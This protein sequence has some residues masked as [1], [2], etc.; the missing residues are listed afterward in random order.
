MLR[1]KGDRLF[2]TRPN[3]K[4]GEGQFEL[5]HI[6]SEDEMKVATLCVEGS[7]PAG[8]SV[9]RHTHEGTMEVCWFTG[10]RGKVIEKDTEY[11]VEAGDVSICFD[12]ETHE[13]INIGEEPLTYLALVLKSG[14]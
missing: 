9:G 7:L 3:F 2:E 11:E 14:N 8:S 4:G 5:R 12:G 13:V 10:G 6:A 1:K